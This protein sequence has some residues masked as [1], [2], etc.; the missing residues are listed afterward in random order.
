MLPDPLFL[1]REITAMGILRDYSA[2]TA[3]DPRDRR[4]EVEVPR[5][6][7]H[8][9]PVERIRRHYVLL[10]RRRGSRVVNRRSHSDL[11]SLEGRGGMLPHRRE[12][13]H[14][15]PHVEG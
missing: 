3:P 13:C 7:A 1:L 4:H 2:G 10:L 14:G 8:I 11:W 12:P 15:L 5:R 9:R 6:P